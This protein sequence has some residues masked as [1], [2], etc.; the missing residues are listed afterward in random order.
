MLVPQLRT[1]RLLLRGWLDDDRE[2]FA[3]LNADPTVMEHFPATLTRA[4]SDAFVDAMIASW[5]E[6]GFGLWCVERPDEPGCIG[7]TGL[8]IPGFEAAFTP[9]VEIGW[10]F[11]H[12]VWG[13]GYAP[14]AARAALDYAW[15]R[16]LD[17]VVSFTSTKNVNSR[18]VMEKIGMLHDPDGDFDH[19]RL[20]GGD[21]LRPHVLYRV[22][23]ST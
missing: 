8:N 16:G 3:E 23:R 10:R 7:F 15:T 2:P 6:Q 20:A 21:P 18:R 5:E 11:A 9:C 13:R 22:R 14:E 4:Q 17:E 19:P 12:H 1:E